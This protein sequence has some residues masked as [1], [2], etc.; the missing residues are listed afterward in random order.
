M[1]VFLIFTLLFPFS[2]VWRQFRLTLYRFESAFE[3]GAFPVFRT[4]TAKAMTMARFL[5]PFS[6]HGRSL[7]SSASRAD[8]LLSGVVP[9]FRPFSG[10]VREPLREAVRLPPT[11]HQGGGRALSRL[12]QSPLRVCP[13]PLSRLPGGTPPD[14]LLPHP[15]LLSLLPRQ[16]ARRV[17]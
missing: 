10:G 4:G 6:H 12:R 14:V 8:C 13:H 7:S 9:L 3:A 16:E 11:H 5:R 15:G 1:S 2:F 17:G